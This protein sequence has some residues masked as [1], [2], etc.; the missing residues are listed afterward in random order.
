MPSPSGEN[1]WRLGWRIV[2]ASATAN[3]TGVSLMF[4]TFSMFLIPLAKELHLTRGEA[5]MVQ[6]LIITAALGAPLVGR[7][8]DTFGFRP[9]FIVA[10]TIMA[11]IELSQA[12]LVDGLYG[13]GLT[14][15]LAGIVGG[16]ASTV[17]LTRPVNA[18]FRRNRGLALGLVGIG[19]S[20]SAALVP[21]ILERVIAIEGW[22]Y[23]FA[24][25]A[26]IGFA[27]GLPLVLALMPRSA[28]VARL[29]P[30]VSMPTPAARSFLASRDFWLLVGAN[31]LVAI[32]TSGAISQLSP[33]IQDEGLS[34]QTAAWGVTA[35]A[36]GQFVGKLGGGFLLDKLEPRLVA[37]VLTAV[38]GLGFGVFL[39][40]QGAAIP[41]LAA[42]M[43]LGVMQGADIGIFAYFVARRF[44]VENYGTVFGALHGFG[45]LGSAIGILGFGLVFDHFGSYALAQL[46]SIGLLAL[47]ALLFLPIR[48]GEAQS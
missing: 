39:L 44:G 14:V 13:L 22:R 40:D 25:L 11:I 32:T 20:I 41:I 10:T 12:W 15:A 18:H 43:L 26:F 38:P 46:A 33:M 5:G 21:P 17:L 9:V 35:F 27:V 6:A 45:W 3:A 36:V 48:L 8:A 7:L 28:S 31:I 24:A 16:G 29:A 23:G 2:A 34:S 30:L 47:A 1:E 19:A 4:Y 37:L 42:G